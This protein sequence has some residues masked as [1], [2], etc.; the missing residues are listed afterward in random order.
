MVYRYI[1]CFKL[2]C[3]HAGN[4]VIKCGAERLPDI[5]R[6]CE[7]GGGTR[8]CDIVRLLLSGHELAHHS[9]ALL[10]NPFTITSS[11]RFRIGV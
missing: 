11:F 10:V 4:R 8:A 7:L 1:E 3:V 5:L 2:H 6:T 9:I